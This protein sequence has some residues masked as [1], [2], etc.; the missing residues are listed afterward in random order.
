MAEIGNVKSSLFIFS[1]WYQ[2]SNFLLLILP[3]QTLG[4]GELWNDLLAEQEV[5]GVNLTK[6]GDD[7]YLHLVPLLRLGDNPAIEDCKHLQNKKTKHKY[8]V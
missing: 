8:L 7:P 4:V 5:G 2:A 1:C 3:H 6:M